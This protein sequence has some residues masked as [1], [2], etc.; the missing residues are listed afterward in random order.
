MLLQLLQDIKTLR[1]LLDYVFRY[2]AITFYQL[3]LNEKSKA[4]AVRDPPLWIGTTAADRCSYKVVSFHIVYLCFVSFSCF[5]SSLMFLFVS[6][7]CFVS[8]LCSFLFRFLV[9]FLYV[10]FCFGFLFRFVFFMFR[11]VSFSFA[12]ATC[13]VV[14]VSIYFTDSSG[15]TYLAV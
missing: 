11:F 3:L 9:S 14:R 8:S 5:A 15:R 1:S 7:S 6:F 2:D 13:C 4:A 10:P 12:F